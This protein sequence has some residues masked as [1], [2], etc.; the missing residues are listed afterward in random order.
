[1][2]S[3]KKESPKDGF[4]TIPATISLEEKELWKSI[5]RLTN[6]DILIIVMILEKEPYSFG[7]IKKKTQFDSNTVNHALI[8]LKDL[9]LVIQKEDKRYYPTKYCQII[10]NALRTIKNEI[11]A[12]YDENLDY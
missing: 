4:F 5:R 12:A 10:L 6:K 7:E 9:G 2:E 3:L 11:A 1:M 8:A